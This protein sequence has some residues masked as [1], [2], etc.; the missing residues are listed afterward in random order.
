MTSLHE[1]L[2]GQSRQ[3][4]GL[5]HLPIEVFPRKMRRVSSISA[6]V[7]G[8]AAV[9]AAASAVAAMFAITVTITAAAASAAA[10][11]AAMSVLTATITAAAASAAAV[12]AAVAASHRECKQRMGPVQPSNGWGQRSRNYA[13]KQLERL[14][15][16]EAMA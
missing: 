4:A 13:A 9:A 15:C 1:H 5:W 8:A 7:A 10:A 14:S 2:Q 11:M 12:A 3:H 16:L 6:A